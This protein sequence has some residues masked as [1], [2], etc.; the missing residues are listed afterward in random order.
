[1]C[2]KH[3]GVVENSWSPESAIDKQYFLSHRMQPLTLVTSNVKKAEQFSQ[4]LGFPIEHVALDLPELQTMDMEAIVTAKAE[5]AYAV[6]KRPILVE[7]AS[8]SF[9][10]LNGLPGP[11]TKFFLQAGGPELLSRL[12]DLHADRRATYSVWIAYKDEHGVHVF[13][14]DSIGSISGSPVLPERLDLVLINVSCPMVNVFPRG[15]S[16]RGI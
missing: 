8:L 11:F 3:L 16:Q 1:M 9:T 13:H 2:T 5:I 14:G 7:D 10:A 15:T 6:L 12:A 4:W